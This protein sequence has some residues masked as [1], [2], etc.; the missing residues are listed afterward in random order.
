MLFR[1]RALNRSTHFPFPIDFFFRLL[2]L[3]LYCCCCCGPIEIEILLLFSSKHGTNLLLMGISP[4]GDTS[5]S[6]SSG[7]LVPMIYI[8]HYVVLAAQVDSSGPGSSFFSL[9]SGRMFANVVRIFLFFFFWLVLLFSPCTPPFSHFARSAVV[10]R[11]VDSI[12][13]YP[14]MV[15]K[16]EEICCQ[17]GP[18]R[19]CGKKRKRKRRRNKQQTITISI[20]LKKKR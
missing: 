18:R 2:L 13:L 9:G 11:R 17:S 10:T 5:F 1:A 20:A 3:Y 15:I 8:M 14:H 6:S 7:S 16:F 4:R 12:S 19:A